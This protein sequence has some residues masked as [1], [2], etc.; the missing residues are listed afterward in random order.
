MIGRTRLVDA[1]KLAPLSLLPDQDALRSLDAY[2]RWWQTTWFVD[3]PWSDAV[4]AYMRSTVT[5]QPD[6]SLVTAATD[7][8]LDEIVASIVGPGGYRRD[9]RRVRAP[10]LFIFAASW[11][12]TTL[13]DSTQRRQAAEWHAQHY[14]PVRTATM[15]RL[16][17]EC[18]G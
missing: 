13:P 18:P 10:A 15:A 4:E 16:R 7:S 9:Y 11:L 17:A 12:P 8:V 6:G 5:K 14:Q 1:L 2:R 3:T